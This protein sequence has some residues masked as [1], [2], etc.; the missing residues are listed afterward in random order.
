MKLAWTQAIIDTI[1]NG[2]L[3]KCEYENFGVF[4]ISIPKVVTG[5]PA[6]ILNPVNL[7]KD[8]AAYKAT[9]EKLAQKFSNNLVAYANACMPGTIATGPKLPSA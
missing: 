1:H 6:E 9:L 2:E 7:W 8:K 4:N 5:M 3:A